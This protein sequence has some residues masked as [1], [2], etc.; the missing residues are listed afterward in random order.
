M[1]TIIAAIAV[2]VVLL[3]AGVIGLMRLV[4]L[5]ERKH[6]IGLGAY[7]TVVAGV[8]MGLVLFTADQR[9]KEHRRQLQEQMNENS[10]RLNDLADRLR[11]QLVEKA[12]LTTSEFE[13]RAKLQNEIANHQ[14][15]RQTLAAQRDEYSTL[16]GVLTGER[17]ARLAY[18]DSL[19]GVQQTRFEQEEARY[20]GLRDFLEVH[21]TTVG[22]MQKQLADVQGTLGQLRAQTGGL[23][24]QQKNLLTQ[25]G[26]NLKGQED[27][28]AKLATLEK[29]NQDL[30]HTLDRAQV[31]VDSLYKWQKTP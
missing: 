1:E 23:Q 13:V 25:V 10:T 16:E 4:E 19:N 24:N 8:V 5:Y 3:W 12:D 21:R 11:A 17:Q 22:N 20:K 2:G 7:T 14:T 27:L 9:Q 26:A 6:L 18:Q 30:R 31:K 29:Q 15:T 28:G